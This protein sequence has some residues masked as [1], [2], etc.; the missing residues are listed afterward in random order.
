M[1]E[2]CRN[3]KNKNYHNYGGRGISVCN[4]WYVFTNFYNWAI[5]NYQ[6]G[7]ELDRENNNGN[8]EP[9]N[10]RFVTDIVNSNNRRNNIFITYTNKTQTLSQWARE[11]NINQKTL[12]YR[13]GRYKYLGDNYPLEKLFA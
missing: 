11:L 2:R 12:S 5:S 10:C 1:I 4:E 6:K 3:I 13:Y 8:Y 7:L 9:E